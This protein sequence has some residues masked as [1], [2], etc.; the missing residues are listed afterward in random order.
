[1]L[2]STNISVDKPYCC[3]SILLIII[4]DKPLV[5]TYVFPVHSLV[6]SLL[7]FPAVG[8]QVEESVE[9]FLPFIAPAPGASRPLLQCRSPTLTL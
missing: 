7:V 5:L 9:A 1:M 6:F 2:I 8:L 3:S 4:K